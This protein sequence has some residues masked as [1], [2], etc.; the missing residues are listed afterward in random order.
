MDEP[1][2]VAVWVTVFGKVSL[3]LLKDWGQSSGV[4]NISVRAVRMLKPGS[5]RM[6]CEP[7]AL[8]L[9]PDAHCSGSPFL[10]VDGPVEFVCKKTSVE[11]LDVESMRGRE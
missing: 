5:P 3:G 6:E 7:V 4:V 8:K 10:S 2:N 9:C 11:R 1:T